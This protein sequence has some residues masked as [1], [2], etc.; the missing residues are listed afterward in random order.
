MIS[1]QFKLDTKA[2]KDPL[3]V[4]PVNFRFTAAKCPLDGKTNYCKNHTKHNLRVPIDCH[5]TYIKFFKL[6]M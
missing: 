3:K 5:F 4:F 2:L 6:L 1:L